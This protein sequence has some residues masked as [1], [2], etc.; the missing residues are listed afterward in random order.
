MPKLSIVIPVY[1]MN[2]QVNQCVASIRRAVDI[3][4][5][6]IIVDD[7]SPV[8]ER[9]MITED[10][11]DVRVLYSEAHQ[12]AAHAV[13]TGMDTASGDVFLFL[14][15]DIMLAPHT[16]EDMLD[17][18]I[19]NPR[20]GAVSAVAAR[21]HERVSFSPEVRYHDWAS[22]I[23][24]AENYRDSGQRPHPAL[25]LE[26]FCTMARRDAVAAAG[27]MDTDYQTPPVAAIDYTL[28]MT[29]AGYHLALLPSV[30]VHH[31]ESVHLHDM[32]AYDREIMAE[33]ELFCAKWGVSLNYSFYARADLFPMMNLTRR[34][35]R[36]LEIGCACGA[37]LMEI[38][39]QN[40]TAKVYG[41]ELNAAAAAIARTYAE[42]LT[43]DV[44]RVVP[45]EISERF[46]YI[47][48]GDV[49]E[50][51]L[52]PWKAIANM[53]QLLAPGGCVIASIPNVAHISNLYN[54]LR[55]LWEYQDFGLLDRTHFR[56]FTQREIAVMFQTAGFEIVDM[57]PRQ[58]KL[59]D[60]MMKLRSEL[61]ALRSVQVRMEDLDSFQWLVCARRK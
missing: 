52:D 37:T 56:F 1:Q 27:L 4:Y 61:L 39:A 32:D 58:F 15:A 2:M 31:Q 41:V 49:I 34:G 35:I 25:Y 5:E 16:V 7:G 42:V 10:S 19:E 28:R 36:V 59:P 22:F 44:E 14:H 50:H 18:L 29:K 55:G 43:M 23:S 11:D 57:R 17:A 38:G 8:E 13:N 51:L 6:V 26:M 21:S 30:Y 46:D 48:M 45:E 3:P 47:V 9:V 12:G 53:R 40:P 20:L 60:P 54:L 24:A 33:R